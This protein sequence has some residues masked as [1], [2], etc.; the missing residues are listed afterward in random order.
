M[1]L[2]ILLYIN[3][4]NY[5]YIY[6]YI[7]WTIFIYIQPLYDV[8]RKYI[9]TYIKQ[10]YRVFFKMI[11]FVQMFHERIDAVYKQL[12]QHSNVAIPPVSNDRGIGVCVLC[13]IF[14]FGIHAFIRL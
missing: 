1:T 8:L 13:L 5:S 7:Y 9:Y 2:C 6:V 12:I 10:L 4:M 11:A 14:R 3:I